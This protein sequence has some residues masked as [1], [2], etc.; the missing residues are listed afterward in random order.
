MATDII[1]EI[2]RITGVGQ[3]ELAAALGTSQAT[4]SRWQSGLN[5]IPKA[6]WDK[7]LR[8]AAADPRT[9][10]LAHEYVIGLLGQNPDQLL[11]LLNAVGAGLKKKA[12]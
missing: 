4:V 9:A 5:E 11:A 1:S 2:S 7:L 12:G 6:A 8:Y 10:H 3:K